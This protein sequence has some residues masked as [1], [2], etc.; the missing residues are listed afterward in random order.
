MAGKYSIIKNVN[1]NVTRKS[2]EFN[3]D[4]SFDDI[5]ISMLNYWKLY[6][7]IPSKIS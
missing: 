3:D 7:E 2:G 6:V 1:G 5:V 4:V